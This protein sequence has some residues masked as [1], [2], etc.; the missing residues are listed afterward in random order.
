MPENPAYPQ[1]TPPGNAGR[2]LRGCYDFEVS[3]QKVYR[4]PNFLRS[5]NGFAGY[6][7]CYGRI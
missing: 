1:I 3:L 6:Q 5:E 4:K 2:G 7:V